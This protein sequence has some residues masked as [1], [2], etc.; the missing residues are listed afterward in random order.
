ML[1][2]QFK[3][4]IICDDRELVYEEAAQAYKNIDSVVELIKE[5]GLI[6]VIARLKPVLSYKTRGGCCE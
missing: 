2:T 5:A 1:E 6:D 4:L 3:S